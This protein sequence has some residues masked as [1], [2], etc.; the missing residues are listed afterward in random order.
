VALIHAIIDDLVA[1]LSH[2]PSQGRELARSIIQYLDGDAGWTELYSATGEL[3]VPSTLE[4]PEGI[5][6]LFST[7][8]QRLAFSRPP[9]ESPCPWREIRIPVDIPRMNIIAAA[10]ITLHSSSLGSPEKPAP[11]YAGQPIS[12]TLSIRTSLHW[13]DPENKRQKYILRYD[14]EE[15]IKDWLVCGHKRGEFI[16]R[17]E[18]FSVP[19]TLIALHHGELTLPEIDVKPLPLAG[20]GM[21]TSVFPNIDTHQA[22]GA[23]T[24][25]V[26]PRGGRS[27]FVV[28]MGLHE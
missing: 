27:T 3:L 22:H 14:I 18:T 9:S 12:A 1:Q 4:I 5:R 25:L 16:T 23:E 2:T 10:R 13:G 15:R 26:L 7:L 17:D 28:G 19:L 8:Q 6:E 11:I 20:D 24:I 21:A